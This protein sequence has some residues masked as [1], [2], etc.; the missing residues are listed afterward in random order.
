MAGRPNT[1]KMASSKKKQADTPK[2]KKCKGRTALVAGYFSY[3]P[4]SEPYVSGVK[5]ESKV[6]GNDVYLS[7]HVCDKCGNVQG[8]CVE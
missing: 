7:A 3:T 8:F 2:C 6:G 5:E 4:D 1:K